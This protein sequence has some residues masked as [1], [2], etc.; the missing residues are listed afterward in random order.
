MHHGENRLELLKLVFGGF[1]SIL[2]GLG[3]LEFLDNLGLG[4]HLILQLLGL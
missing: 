1:D 4:S 3:R 2:T